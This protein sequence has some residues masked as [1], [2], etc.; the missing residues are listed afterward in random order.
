MLKEYTAKVN[1]WGVFEAVLE[2]T[3]EGN[4]FA[5]Q[6][7]SGI[8]TSRNESVVTEGFYDGE[9]IY[10][11]RFMP[12]YEG[13]YT[14]V[15]KPSWTNE[16]YT[17]KF[18]VDA[19][20]EGNHGP[21]RTVNTHHFA[22]ED[23]TPYISIGTTAYVW[24][25]Q[26]DEL[27]EETLKTL[28]DSA[29][30][31]IRFCVF[32]KH[33]VYNLH[34][35]VSYPYEGTPMDPAVLNEDNF[36]QYSTMLNEQDPSNQFDFKRFNP[37]HFRR[38]EHYIEALGKR[39][40][41]ADL[42]LL[43]PYDR[44]GFACMD[45]EEDDLY[46]RYVVSRFA[47][48][49]NVWWA[50]ANEYDLMKRKTI[51]DWERLAD[52]LVRRDPY[53][54]LRSIHNCRVMYDHS[55][56]WITHCSVQ[57]IDLYKGAELTGELAQR[58]QKPVV[59]DE[60]AYEGNLEN[61]WGNITAEEMVR[62][63]WETAV[64][65]GYPG[66]GE[67]YLNDDG[68]I[69]WSHGGRLHGESWKR[70]AFLHEILQDVPG[71]GLTDASLEWDSTSGVPESEW[72]SPIKSQYLF[73]YGFMRPSFRTFCIDQD[74][75]FAVDVIDTW[76]MTIEK[77]GVFKGKFRIDLP[78]RQYMA[79][80]LRRPEE[81]DY[82]SE[83]PEVEEA[84]AEEEEVP[85]LFADE[86]EE[87]TEE[88]AAVTAPEAEPEPEPEPEAEPVPEP[89]PEPEPV[90]K[91]PA[92]YHEPDPFNEIEPEINELEED[93]IE[94][95]APEEDEDSPQLIE[96]L[97]FDREE[98]SSERRKARGDTAFSLIGSLLSDDDDLGEDELPEI[99]TSKIPF[100]NE[101]TQTQRTART[102]D[103]S[104]TLHIPAIGRHA[105]KG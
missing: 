30:N 45:Q 63:F 18:Y 37:A 22:Y 2:G 16:S 69:W 73:Y 97:V 3:A 31:K 34:E 32:P 15:L 88:I 38:I 39:G 71:N 98:T 49:H 56:P 62:R 14:F 5:E 11:I 48:Y 9:G 87:V 55:R 100:V 33:Y 72:F 53:R 13:K 92:A 91:E 101:R 27:A 99:I 6:R 85:V 89:E 43:H 84:P 77:K 28:E 80:R 51:A 25:L 1:K 90:K 58:Y 82:L 86:P 103:N 105:R 35:P 42:I 21:V 41:E 54:H 65:G 40:I 52:I 50:L 67:T 36:M 47:A 44:W 66:H 93:V 10:R 17:G 79:I 4:P 46:F 8:F 74:T 70:F 12:S 75:E 64:R 76:N 19:A 23:G 95:K 102:E 78:A 96:D 83:E 26:N 57:R 68:V 104:D 81:D 20:E 59:M 60:I 29:F 94:I 61:G 24:A 7:V